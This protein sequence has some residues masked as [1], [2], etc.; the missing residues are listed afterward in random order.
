MI[1]ISKAAFV[2]LIEIMRLQKTA[3]LQEAQLLRNYNIEPLT[4]KLRELEEEFSH[5]IILKAWDPEDKNRE[6]LGSV[7]GRQDKDTL[8][9]GKLMVH[10]RHQRKGLGRRLLKAIEEQFPAAARCELF[11]GGSSRSNMELYAKNGYSEFKRADSGLGF[12]LV[13]MEK[14]KI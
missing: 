8:Y 9:I 13:F 11:T 7:R 5:S 1:E 2:D 10:P 12:D 14:Q 3:F 4:Q 6:I